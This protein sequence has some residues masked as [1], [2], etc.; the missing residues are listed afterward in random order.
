VS[1]EIWLIV[2]LFGVVFVALLSSFFALAI[3]RVPVLRTPASLLPAIGDALK[4]REGQVLVDAGCADGRTLLSLCKTSR[5]RGRGY[6]LNGPVWLWA[7]VRV[8]LSGLAGRVR[9]VWKD[10]YRSELEDV[11]VVYCYLM[12]AVM[13]R[14]A[15][16]CATE[17]V[18]AARLASFLWAVPGCEAHEILPL[19]RAGDPLYIYLVSDLAAHYGSSKPCQEN[20]PKDR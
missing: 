7:N 9:I 12:P 16:K 10:F 17:M 19:G 1:C 13:E 15:V 14:V 18:P 8:L 6:E 20:D 5:A 4:L 11:D 3:T 2:A